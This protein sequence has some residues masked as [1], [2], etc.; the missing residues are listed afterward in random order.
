MFSFPA[1]VF[2]FPPNVFSLPGD[3]FSFRGQV[4]S[5]RRRAAWRLGGLR[6][7]AV[8]RW[9]RADTEAELVWGGWPGGRET[10]SLGRIGAD[11]PR[12]GAARLLPGSLLA[13]DSSR[14]HLIPSVEYDSLMS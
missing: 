8:A 6:G 7:E 11:S 9:V 2:T 1:N 10:E 14:L 12:T 4:F 3:V 5:C 13:A